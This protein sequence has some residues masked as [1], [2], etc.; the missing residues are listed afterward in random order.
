M[1]P[2]EVK[3]E[4]VVTYGN[5]I[6]KSAPTD[7]E[8]GAMNMLIALF[9]RYNLIAQDK[10]KP[11]FKVGDKVIVNSKFISEIDEIDTKGYPEYPYHIQKPNGYY[12]FF[13]E[14]DLEPYIPQTAEASDSN[15]QNCENF[16]K[17]ASTSVDYAK[18][19]LE[20]AKEI[21]R[22]MANYDC[23]DWKRAAYNCVAMTNEIVHQ[24][25]KTEE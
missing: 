5:L 21:A 17:N 11:K 1:L 19:R 13:A 14:N 2:E 22:E 20:L 12:G 4:I 16:T 24:L 10:E 9:G 7:V 6:V 3:T 15:D 23:D 25:K 8:I 18:Y